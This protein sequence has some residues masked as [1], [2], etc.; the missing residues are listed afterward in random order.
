MI[1]SDVYDHQARLRSDELIA[2]AAGAPSD[3]GA[4]MPAEWIETCQTSA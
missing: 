4:R 2:S 3:T 1:T